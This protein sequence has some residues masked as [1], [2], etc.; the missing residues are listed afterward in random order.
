MNA[1]PS[2]P[3]RRRAPRKRI[4]AGE[5]VT[6]TGTDFGLAV[7]SEVSDGM[8]PCLFDETGTATRIP[9]PDYDAGVWHAFVPALAAGQT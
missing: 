4:T 7:V 2:C 8:V 6:D 5:T 9:M 1:A 3:G